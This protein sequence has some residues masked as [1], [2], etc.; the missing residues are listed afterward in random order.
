MLF[1]LHIFDTRARRC[2]YYYAMPMRRY[3]YAIIAAVITLS[4]A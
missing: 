3:C 2:H 1:S 4:A